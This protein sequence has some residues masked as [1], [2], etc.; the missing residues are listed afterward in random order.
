[1]NRRRFAFFLGM[2]LFW[3][4]DK[5]R[6]ESVDQLAA[7]LMRSTE[8]NRG[9]IRWSAHEN[10]RW[11]WY[12]R[13]SLTAGRWK[14][15]GVTT[16]I[17]RETGK[18]YTAKTGYLS[19]TEVPAEILFVDRSVATTDAAV[20]KETPIGVSDPLRRQREGRPPS[21]WLRSLTAKEIHVWLKTIEVP[22]FGVSGMTFWT[23]LTRDHSFE[24]NKIEGLSLEDQAKLHAAAH[25]GY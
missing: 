11:R 2:G 4:S 22:E 5:L 7:T 23:H 17:N 25:C 3:L 21:Q 1:M 14:L 24:A 12:E 19:E 9:R 16:P 10:R 8:K 20:E 6:A 13:E 18:P 15:T